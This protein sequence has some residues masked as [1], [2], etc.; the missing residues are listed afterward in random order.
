MIK[1]GAAPPVR[2]NIRNLELD[3]LAV[4]ALLNKEKRAVLFKSISP[5]DKALTELQKDAGEM[6]HTYIPRGVMSRTLNKALEHILSVGKLE[7]SRINVDK[8]G[9]FFEL[10]PYLFCPGGDDDV[11][12]MVSHYVANTWAARSELDVVEDIGK[13]SLDYS[14]RVHWGL[15]FP[16]I[17]LEDID[18]I[19]VRE[20][21]GS[22]IEQLLS[23]ALPA[24]RPLLKSRLVQVPVSINY[25]MQVFIDSVT[26]QIGRP[27]FRIPCK[28]NKLY[29]RSHLLFWE[30]QKNVDR[31]D[32]RC[33]GARSEIR[34]AIEAMR[35]IISADPE[36]YG[37]TGES[38]YDPF[39][40]IKYAIRTGRADNPD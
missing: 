39:G 1:T 27:P 38:Y 8:R 5:L 21:S 12:F 40:I 37:K 15:H 4:R 22:G 33:N 3:Q 29:N 30:I 6:F 19:C 32:E 31:S 18:L 20:R 9:H 34:T 10:G 35:D 7:R 16:D 17:D 23:A 24:F 25:S 36:L 2:F 14:M 11:H 28:G 13:W 26:R